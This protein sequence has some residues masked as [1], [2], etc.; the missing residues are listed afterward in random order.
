MRG[1]LRSTGALLCVATAAV[2]IFGIT[3]FLI[4]NEGQGRGTVAP[5]SI[6]GCLG[7]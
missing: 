5:G 6:A 1:K 7:V 3:A 4:G 2:V